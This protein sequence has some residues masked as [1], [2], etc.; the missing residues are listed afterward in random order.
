MK[1]S[2]VQL[3][4]AIVP[5]PRQTRI[6]SAAVRRW[7]GANI[8]PSTETTASKARSGKGSAW[9]SPSTVSTA[10]PSAAARVR[11]RSSREGT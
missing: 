11:A 1:P 2:G 10:S 7:S 8:A 9:A 5:P 3:A 6:I 4:S